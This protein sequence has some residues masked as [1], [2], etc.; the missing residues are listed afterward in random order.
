[1]NNFHFQGEWGT[2][3]HLQITKTLKEERHPLK[4][5]YGNVL[6]RGDLSSLRWFQG[7]STPE[8]SEVEVAYSSINFKDVMLATGRLAVETC[9]DTRLKQSLVLGLEYSGI[10]K[11]TGRRIMGMSVKGGIASHI[12][13]IT[14]LWWDVPQS[15]T[16]REAATAPVVYTTVYY[17]FF[18]ITKI[19]KGQSILIHAGTG[20]IGLAAIRTAIMYGLEVFTTCSSEEKKKYILC[21]FPQ[22]KASHVGNSRDSSFEDMVMTETNGRGVDYVLNSLS[23]DM[24]LASVRCLGE[25]GTFLEIGKF[26]MAADNKIGLGEFLKGISFRVV[27]VDQLFNNFHDKKTMEKVAELREMID[28]DMANNIIQPLPSTVFISKD[29]EQAFRHLVGGKHIGKVLIQVRDTLNSKQILP[30]KMIP[31]VYFNPDLIYII[32][33]GLGGFG[34]ELADWMVLRGARKL[35]LSSSRGIS[36]SYQQYRIS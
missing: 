9:G 25:G 11:K 27:L 22:V 14:P 10:H 15:W 17:A 29:I 24:L 13:K 31:Q 28:N 32:A 1:M 33:G 4:H 20:G 18:F 8:R 19:Q 3:R 5:F 26:D 16:L 7:P 35:I 6:N 2:Y 34:L 12:T 23:E 30:V 36:Q 21:T